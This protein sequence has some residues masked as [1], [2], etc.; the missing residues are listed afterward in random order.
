MDNND[1]DFALADSF[2]NFDYTPD[3]PPPLGSGS[4]HSDPPVVCSGVEDRFENVENVQIII[5]NDND[6]AVNEMDSDSSWSE[7]TESE[8]YE[9]EEGEIVDSNYSQDKEDDSEETTRWC[10]GVGGDDD[11][12]QSQ[13]QGSRTNEL[14]VLLFYLWIVHLTIL[15]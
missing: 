4:S 15:P 5:A 11:D 2:I 1:D 12:D 7:R 14:E 8:V 13:S 3:S 10:F 9:Y 6:D